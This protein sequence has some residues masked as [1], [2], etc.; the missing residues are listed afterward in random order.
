[1]KKGPYK[2]KYTNGKK[3]DASAFPFSTDMPGMSFSTG[4]F[5]KRMQENPSKAPLAGS[6]GGGNAH[7]HPQEA[8]IN[9]GQTS[10]NSLDTV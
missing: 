7:T 1:M 6:S 3:A 9:V 8:I 4:E 10:S 5:N 2:M